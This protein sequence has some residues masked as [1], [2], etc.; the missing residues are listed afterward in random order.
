MSNEVLY[1][2]WRFFY[3]R[4]W[5]NLLSAFL[6]TFAYIQPFVWYEIPAVART[7][8]FSVLPL[9]TSIL[10]GSGDFLP[11]KPKGE[12]AVNGVIK[13]LINVL[14]RWSQGG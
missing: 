4:R 11:L 14:A 12:N 13:G 9:F 6:A 8:T 3:R 7:R 1:R 5:E 2:S 10:L